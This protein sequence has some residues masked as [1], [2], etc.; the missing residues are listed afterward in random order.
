[1]GRWVLPAL[2]LS[3]CQSADTHL[4]RGLDAIGLGTESRPEAETDRTL[5]RRIGAEPTNARLHYQN[6]RYLLVSNSHGDLRLARVAFMNASRFAPDSWK[7][8]LGLAAAEYRLGDY[9]A[10]LSAFVQAIDRRAGCSTA[11][12]GLALIAFRAG[13]FGLAA[14]A[15]EAAQRA[16]PPELPVERRAAKFLSLAFADGPQARPLEDVLARLR[17]PSAPAEAVDKGNVEI[18]AY[19]IRKTRNSNSSTGINLLEALKLQ[20]G[21]TIVNLNHTKESGNPGIQTLQRS[22]EVSVPSVTYAMNVASE[23][24]STFSLEASPSVVGKAGKSSRFF[25]GSTVMIVPQ[26][27]FSE[28]VERDIGINLKVTPDEVGAGGVDLSATMELSNLTGNT[29]LGGAV[30][31]STDKTVAEAA[32]HIPFGRAMALGS[33]ATM[34]TRTG[35]S[36]V[37][38]LRE[39]PVLGN[40]LGV[41]TATSRRHDVLALISVRKAAPEPVAS[42]VDEA[43]ASKRLFGVVAAPPD[44]LSRLPYQVPE[45]DFLDWLQAEEDDGIHPAATRRG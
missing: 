4:V 44:R 6:G 23:D 40:L 7:P 16:G 34:V 29:T 15:W 20:F 1:M 28:Q 31:L 25:D 3:A 37:P 38:V 11:C 43:A 2:L 36:G 41:D 35:E 17:R 22:I 12:Y 30:V 21:A 42:P 13:Y 5:F 27:D 26:G 39:V 24:T 8:E 14:G 32:A 45:I 10:A 18:A 19:I 9:D 33:G